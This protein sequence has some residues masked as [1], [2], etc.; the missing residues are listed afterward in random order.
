MG[1]FAAEGGTIGGCGLRRSGCVGSCGSWGPGGVVFVCATVGASRA[2]A[3]IV[4]RAMASSRA[5]PS[6]IPD[7]G[8]GLGAPGSTSGLPGSTSSAVRSVPHACAPI[9]FCSEV[10]PWASSARS[11]RSAPT[12]GKLLGDEWLLVAT[13]TP[14]SAGCRGWPRR[15]IGS[16]LGA[17]VVG[18]GSWSTGDGSWSMGAGAWLTGASSWPTCASSCESARSCGAPASALGARAWARA[19][20]VL[21]SPVACTSLHSRLLGSRTR[22]VASVVRH[23]ARVVSSVATKPASRSGRSSPG[24]SGPAR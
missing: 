16:R 11:L 12:R 18:V 23:S 17:V 5:W 15:G 13:A 4:R 24:S 6:M 1:A 21:R 2:F 22:S 20:L 3:V 9:A 8:C 19:S 10:A 14:R 7:R